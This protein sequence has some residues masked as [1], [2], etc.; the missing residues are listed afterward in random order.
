M[1]A[2]QLLR[3]AS[4]ACAVHDGAAGSRQPGTR[5]QRREIDRHLRP[6]HVDGLPVVIARRLAGRQPVGAAQ[7]GIRGRLHHRRRP[8]LD[9]GSH[10]SDVLPGSGADRAGYGLAEAECEH[11]GGGPLSGRR[12]APGR[13][14]LDLLHGH[15]PGRLSRHHSLR[16]HRRGLQLPLGLLSG[17]HRH[18][19][20]F[21]PV[22]DGRET[23]RHGGQLEER[24]PTGGAQP[25]EPR[26][27]PGGGG[28]RGGDYLVHL[29]RHKRR[30]R[31]HHPAD[32]NL[33]RLRHPH[34]ERPV[35]PLSLYGGRLD[36]DREEAPRRDCVALH[37]GGDVLVG[38]RAGR[39]VDEHLC[40]RPHRP[41]SGGLGDARQ[42]AAERESRFHR[43]L[44]AHLRLAMDLAC[45]TGCESVDPDEVRTGTL[46]PGCRLLRDFMGGG[47]CERGQ[48]RFNELVGGDLFPPHRR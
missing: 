21:D 27:L 42:L 23:P 43:D 20:G 1:G 25:Q 29:P 24:R 7:G 40:P 15:Q 48:P 12:R 45:P 36:G 37:P 16:I 22:Q 13:R 11:H 8:F 6:V 31:G 44:R 9:G 47:Q 46:R 19:S 3:D 14:L 10:V 26:L 41:G 38:I 33:A 34:P 28:L 4:P 35:L 17:R 30:D 2:I 5:I 18:G 32:G 39:F